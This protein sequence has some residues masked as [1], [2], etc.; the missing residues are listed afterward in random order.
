MES[1]S[2]LSTTVQLPGPLRLRPSF[3]FV[4]RPREMAAL[5]SLMP[6]AENE[7]RR[8]ALVGGA[9]GSGKSRLVREFAHQAA[10]EGVLVLYGACDAVV[11]TPY[12]PLVEALDQ[13]VRSSDPAT[14]RDD[15]G[16][17]GG[18]LTRLLPDLPAT[19]G[20]LPDPV[21]ADQDTERHRLNAAVTDLLVAVS[22]RRPVLL[23]VEDGHWADMPTL[24]LLRHLA[25]A[26]SDA[27]MLLL[28]TFRDTEADVP[29]EL[30]ETLVEMRRSEGVVRLRLG[31][32]T[33]EEVAEFVALTSGATLGDDLPQLAAAIT[34]L[35]EGNAFL[36]TELW[37]ALVETEALEIR[38]GVARLTRPLSELGTPETVRE[39][40]SQR[41]SR[42]DP[43]T[44]E[45]LEMAAVAGPEFDLSVLRAAG[46]F[47][48]D[49][50]GAALDQS[51]RSGMIEQVPARALR[52]RFTHE[53]VRR[54]LYDRLAGFRRA[55][56]HLQVANALE[57]GGAADSARGLA[58][59]AHHFAAAAP[60]DGPERAVEYNLR[61]AAAATAALAFDEAVDPLRTALEL[62]V[63]NPL[64]RAEIELE[65]GTACY[66][67]GRSIESLNAFRGVAET[68]RQLVDPT[69]LARAAIGFENSCWRVAIVD[70]GAIELL[71]EALAALDPGDSELRVMLLAGLGRACSFVGDHQRSAELRRL[72]IEMARRID[73]RPG[74]ASVLMRSYWAR[75]S[76]SLDEILEM[77]TEAREI[78]EELGDIEV[79]AESMEWRIAALIAKGELATAGVELAAV[80]EAADRIHQPFILHVAEQYASAIALAEGRLEESDAAAERSREWSRWLTGRDASGVHGIQMFGL[81]REQGRLAEL[82]PVVRVLAGGDRPGGAWRP[83]LAAVMAEL[84]MHDEAR[85]QLELL[86]RDGLESY[87]RGLWVA[88]LTYIADACAAVGDA[89]LARM[90]YDELSPHAGGNVMIGHGVACYGSTDRYLG[91]LA[92]GFGELALAEQHIR[93]AMAFN[94]RMG[95]LTWLAHSSYEYARVLALQGRGDHPSV[96]AALMEAAALA[97][98]IGMPVLLGRIRAMGSPAAT[99]AR[100]PDGLSPREVEI[101]RRVAQGMS[102]KEIGAALHISEHTAANHIR[103]ILRKTGCANRTEAASYAHT[104]GLANRG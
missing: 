63:P 97:E 77:L 62:G 83:A 54:A 2:T 8:I 56:L 84:G 98:R 23:V 32:L 64:A 26:S 9:P 50:L 15:L 57:A 72:T 89:E 81:R 13:L 70:E 17:G 40:V 76:A 30:S 37:R 22:H 85:R 5:R 95:A 68:G 90:V 96:A 6:R 33:S 71:E 91:T 10:G 35:T 14:L 36:M 29:A 25:R 86:R 43:A 73:F 20:P 31:G 24:L 53:L 94:R 61:A 88:S 39:V 48:A 21:V 103:S 59:L 80:R 11:R 55:E 41:L 44:S 46:Q 52:Y 3:P 27:R 100:L 87:R 38:D 78:G 1:E 67:A 101:L 79:V 66:R 82:A 74:L 49:T 7:G 75:G 65:L 19:V 92:A 34:D 42:L 18:E 4:G 69:L 51:E 60:V 45:V 99:R 58:S 47:D 104:R 16:S 12:R 28:A 93:L 102:N